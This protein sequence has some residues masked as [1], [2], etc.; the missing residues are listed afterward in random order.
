MRVVVWIPLLLC[1]V[2]SHTVADSSP[3][4]DLFE[5][6]GVPAPSVVRVA[7]ADSTN[8]Q[9][10]QATDDASLQHAP[11]LAI[12]DWPMVGQARLK[13]LFWNIYDS[14]LYTPSGMWQGEGPY[15]LSLHYLRDIPVHQLIEQTDKAWREQGRTHPRQAEWLAQLT[16]IWP[17]ITEGDNLVLSVAASGHSGFWF[18]GE[19]IGAIQDED[20]GPLFGGIWLDADSPQPD[21]RAKLIASQEIFTVPRDA[22]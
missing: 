11:P 21:L 6:N 17:D 13:V 1:W 8:A 7:M 18:N 16:D 3:L 14:A 2:S 12:D 22:R 4:S 10:A 20:F 19:Y 15:Q 5:S 9:V